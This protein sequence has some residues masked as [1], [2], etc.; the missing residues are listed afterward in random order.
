MLPLLS[1]YMNKSNLNSVSQHTLVYQQ[2]QKYK[3]KHNLLDKKL[4]GEFKHDF[5]GQYGWLSL[6]CCT[7][8]S[9]NLA[10]TIFAKLKT[11]RYEK[12][13]IK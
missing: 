2:C 8:N 5:I 1:S 3:F 10:K 9:H 12:Q 4:S 11:L 7:M 13:Q 6:I